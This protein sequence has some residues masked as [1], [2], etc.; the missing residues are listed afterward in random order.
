M[1][2]LDIV[3]NVN[4]VHQSNG[5]RSNPGLS[6]KCLHE[7]QRDGVHAPRFLLKSASRPRRQGGGG[8]VEKFR[9]QAGLEI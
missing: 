2:S 1:R 9:A 6:R 8:I 4:N 3:N 7:A 5:R